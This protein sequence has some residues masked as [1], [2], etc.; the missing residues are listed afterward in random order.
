MGVERAVGRRRTRQLAVVLDAVRAS[1]V[2]HPSAERVH[3][4]V[5]RVLP[6]ISLGTVY[7]NLQRLTDEGRIGVAQL[8]GRVSRYDPT[9]AA[10]DHFVCRR[11]GRVD[12][13][14]AS[15]PLEGMRAARRAGHVVTSHAIVLYGHCRSCQT[16]AEP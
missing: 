10:H 6:T 4:C 3:E 16:G 2:E 12:D 9:P 14:D 7:R 1:G 13:L 8:E 15:V 5:R 11:C